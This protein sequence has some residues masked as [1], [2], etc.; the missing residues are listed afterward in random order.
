MCSER[1]VAD[2]L[3]ISRGG[4]RSIMKRFKSTGVTADIPKIGRR[5]QK[6]TSKTQRLIAIKSKL[7]PRWT[8]NMLRSD[9]SINHLV[10]VDA[11]KRILRR[12]KLFGRVAVKK[13]FHSK[14]NKTIED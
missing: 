3:E 14:I 5:R 10:S 11:V 4:V 13:P 1:D 2:Q 8:A 9:C 12:A 7:N 6:L